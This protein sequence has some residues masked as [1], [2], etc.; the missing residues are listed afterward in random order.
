VASVR[1]IA[2]TVLSALDGLLVRQTALWHETIRASQ[3][4]WSEHTAATGRVIEQALTDA[5]STN[6]RQHAAALGEVEQAIAAQS[7][8]HWEGVQQA[9]VQNAEAARLQQHELA[10]QAE[11]LAQV[12]GATDQVAE[13]ERTLNHNL[14]A[15]SGARHFEETVISLSAAIGL[16][17]ARLGAPVDAPRVELNSGK[18]KGQAA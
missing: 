7:R 18:R 8:Q 10:R 15:L 14:A 9:L 12:A 5:L 17:S 1:H 3:A 2:E 13:L 6:V 16:L 11:L 4:Q